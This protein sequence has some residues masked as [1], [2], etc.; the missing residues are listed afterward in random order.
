MAALHKLTPG[1][2]EKMRMRINKILDYA[3]VKGYRTGDN[4]ARLKGHFEHLPR[5]VAPKS[6]PHPA[7]PSAEVPVLMR[8]LLAG[9]HDLDGGPYQRNHR[10]EMEGNRGRPA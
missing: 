3:T 2:A 7:M 4:P 5:Q 10:C 1:R 6:E 9:F 8:E